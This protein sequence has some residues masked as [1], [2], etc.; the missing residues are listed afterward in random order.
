MLLLFLSLPRPSPPL[1][2]LHMSQEPPFSPFTTQQLTNA[3]T[4]TLNNV[5]DEQDNINIETVL[6]TGP[7]GR[8][9]TADMLKL[10]HTTKGN[11]ASSSRT[12]NNS[13]IPAKD[14]AIPSTLQGDVD[15]TV[16]AVPIRGYH[17]LMV[18]S[19]TS[20]L[21]VPHMVYADEINVDELT[22]MRDSLCPLAKQ[23]GVDK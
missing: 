17:R 7:G 23:L 18:K 16:D 11:A 6:G 5:N 14:A 12:N 20:S 1:D 15:R 3:Q 2:V 21:Q 13:S 8:V 22:S 10:L 19:M 9:L 4:T